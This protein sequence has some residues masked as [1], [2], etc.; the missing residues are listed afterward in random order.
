MITKNNIGFKMI[1]YLLLINLKLQEIAGNILLF[2]R[3]RI[4]KT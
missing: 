4:S 3:F 2:L 1:K